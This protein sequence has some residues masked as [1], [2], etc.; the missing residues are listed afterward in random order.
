MKYLSIAESIFFDMSGGWDDTC[1]GGI[2]W[3]KDRKYKNAIANE[4]FLS[5]A[6]H[7]ANRTSGT[8]QKKYLN[9]AEKEWN[10]F[11]ASD[12]INSENLIN[13]GLGNS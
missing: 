5:V 13:D 3:S 11:R 2:W 6:A 7:L 10:W 1:R 8:E 4:L 9:W 12:L